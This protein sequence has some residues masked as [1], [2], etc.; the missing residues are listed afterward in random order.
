[1]DL[2]WATTVL[3]FAMV[4]DAARGHWQ[5]TPWFNIDHPGG[6]GDHER[7]DAI[8]RY[9]PDKLCPT[10]LG[11]EA[12]T[13]QGVPAA[14]TGEAVHL[15]HQH[16][17]W[18]VN[19][20][21][22]PRKHCSNYAV[23]F[24]CPTGSASRVALSS[25]SPWSEW[26]SCS[27]GCERTGV[28]TRSRACSSAQLPD[29]QQHCPGPLQEGRMCQGQ[30]CTVTPSTDLRL[31]SVPAKS[32]GEQQTAGCELRCAMGRVNAACTQ[33]MC[34]D[35]SLYGSVRLQDGAPA[36]EATV[37][38]RGSSNKALTV[39]DNNGKF[40][41]PGLCPDGKT[42]LE[43]RKPYYGI[44]V[45]TLHQN[46]SKV[47]T[48]NIKLKRSEKPFIKKQPQSKVRREGQGVTFCC[49][50]VC[51]PPANKYLWYHN[52]SLLDV[53]TAGSG[54]VL[55]LHQLQPQQ[56]GQY[57]CHASNSLGSIK[58]KPATL[59]VTVRS[60]PSCNPTPQSYFIRLPSD[61]YQN[62][63]QSFYY[64]V[65]KCPVT[66][67]AST[68]EPEGQCRDATTYCCG[69]VKLEDSVISCSMYTLPIRVVNR[70]GCQ[71]CVHTKAIVRGRAVA[72]DDGEPMRFGQIFMGG[73]KISMTGYKGT[74]S[75][76]VPADIDRFVLTFVDRYQKFVNTTKVLPFNRKGG[77]VFHEVKLLRKKPEIM[78]D[79]SISNTI[80]LGSK[81]NEDPVAE[82]EIPPNSFY[83]ENGEIYRGLVK[84]SVTFLDPR[85]ISLASAAQSDLNFINEEGDV[86][87]L[88]TYGMFSLDFRDEVA[89]DRLN[90]GQVKLFLD[91]AQVNIPEHLEQMKLWSLNPETGFWEE[92][93]FFTFVR[94]RRGKREERTFL[95]GNMEIR[96]RRLFNLDVPESRRCYVKVRSFR[97]DRFTSGDQLEGVVVSL[98]NLEP[99]PG[100]AS[101]PRAW[102][103]FDSAVTGANG[104][105]VPAFCDDQQPHAYSAYV[106]AT[107]GGEELEAVA[108]SPTVNS[109]TVGVQQPFLHKLQYRRSDHED[110]RDKKTAFRINVAKPNANLPAE[111][112]GPIYPYEKL[113]ECEIA[114]FSAG[115]FRFYRVEG[116][117][118]EYNTVAFNENDPMSWTE[119]YLAWWP[120]PMEFRACYIKLKL[121]G[122][123]EITV[124][125]RNMGGTH[126]Q[127]VGQMYGLRDVRSTRDATQ[128][129]VSAVCLEFKCSGM[130]YDQERVDRTMVKIIPQGHCRMESINNMLREYLVNHLPLAV[131]NDTS[132]FTMLAP[133]DPLGHNYGI[134]TVT[135][136]DPV[137]AKEMA[138]G[139]CFDGSSDSVSRV[140]KSNVGVALAF[141]CEDKPVSHQ[142]VF[143]TLQNFPGQQ[144]VYNQRMG[145][146]KR[147]RG[148]GVKLRGLRLAKKLRR[149]REV[150]RRKALQPVV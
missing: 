150:P 142:N 102:G 74:F 134:Y 34:E 71:R 52:G 92:E 123:H 57:M 29:W 107:L 98:I 93:G 128:P 99:M 49:Q 124:R 14:L 116:D 75:I 3:L 108:S 143:Q 82:L 95:V 83:R 77:S 103:R 23:R 94:S 122:M 39:C 121:S 27:A 120:R 79:C 55:V 78:L 16:G 69:A 31:Q 8:Q 63:S 28:Q 91:T 72:A 48:I 1:M 30:P 119:D 58:S 112:N 76:M 4:C 80:S 81:E 15:S 86:L 18:C 24:R 104:A 21:Q 135:D 146:G 19:E 5:W 97:G 44:A 40:R 33:C 85:D 96:E 66:A 147:G 126:P 25:W 88:R 115:H 10:P 140:M 139:R 59:T 43:I 90:A 36:S 60:A 51:N 73:K 106:T 67:C 105:C 9:Y 148:K 12:R 47:S 13:M 38:L 87:P 127:T 114:H 17:F 35:H 42:A 136:Q 132:E 46:T 118:Y 84:A 45:V 144:P 101:N 133:L 62:L 64:D 56:A 11:V 70:C 89:N 50:V 41:I 141:N 113:R 37:H 125:S 138:L 22:P 111:I 110:P 131:N 109:N 20:E 7:L 54:S 53:R 137:T 145:R 149:H 129:G 26:G 2:N 32:G 65:G 100:F 61:C 68:Q 6:S 130:L 117:K